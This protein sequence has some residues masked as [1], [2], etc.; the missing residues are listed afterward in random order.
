MSVEGKLVLI[1][2]MLTSLAML[3]VFFEVPR[4]VVENLIA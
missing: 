2:S 1:Y 4:R 3:M